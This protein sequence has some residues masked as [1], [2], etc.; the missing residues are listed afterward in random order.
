MRFGE[1]HKI[2]LG[3]V[4]VVS[5][6]E[7][8]VRA[9]EMQKII[10]D[11][12]DPLT[13]KRDAIIAEKLAM[14]KRKTFKECCKEFM[15]TKL[16]T[17]RNDTH[18]RQWRRTL[19][20]TYPIMGDIPVADIDTDIVERALKPVWDRAPVTASRLRGRIEGVLD[21]ATVKKFRQGD[22]PARWTGHLEHVFP[23]K[24]KQ[25]KHHRAL[26]IDATPAFMAELR[27]DESLVARALEFTILTA[28]RTGEIIKAD[29]SEVNFKTKLW[30]RPADHMKGNEEHTVPLSD[31]ALAILESLPHREGRIFDITEDDMRKYLDARADATP[32]GFRSTFSDWAGE[33][34]DFEP[35]LVEFALAHKLPNKVAAAYRRGTAV[36]RRRKLMEEWAKFCG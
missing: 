20:E 26:P 12:K 36:E 9:K 21:W 31:R 25:Q 14:V 5:L 33:C 24:P 6:A 22:N 2:G 4:N 19:E 32:H 23:A 1:R 35:Q 3:S 13:L 7:A 27:R 30:V 16:P 28:A 18:R 17:M 11:G 29:W 10:L 15:A 34:T 8:R